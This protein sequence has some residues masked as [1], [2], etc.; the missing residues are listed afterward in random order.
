[1]SK[2]KTPSDHTDGI[3]ST[4]Q[5]L[6][7]RTCGALLLYD[8]STLLFQGQLTQHSG[9]HTLDTFQRRIQQLQ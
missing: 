8:L 2:V 5:Q 7:Q 1:M 9:S 6:R 4:V 3:V